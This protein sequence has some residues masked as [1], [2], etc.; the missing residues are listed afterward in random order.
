MAYVNHITIGSN[1]DATPCPLYSPQPALPKAAAKSWWGIAALM[2]QAFFFPDP[3]A[4]MRFV[5]AM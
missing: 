3:A 2:R 4:G 5:V 1:G